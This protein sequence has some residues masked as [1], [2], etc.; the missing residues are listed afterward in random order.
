[1]RGSTMIKR[2]IVYKVENGSVI[3]RMSTLTAYGLEASCR[4]GKQSFPADV[5]STSALVGKQCLFNS[6]PDWRENKPTAVW[7]LY[8]CAP[9]IKHLKYLSLSQYSLCTC[10]SASLSVCIYLC[11]HLSLFLR[12][13]LSFLFYVSVYIFFSLLL[14]V[15]LRA[16]PEWE[17]KRKKSR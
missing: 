9:L 14:C 13:Y 6:W 5:Y 11:M 10:L 15:C 8:P 17:I 12:L 2:T 16:W 4:Q 3:H 7:S 1:M